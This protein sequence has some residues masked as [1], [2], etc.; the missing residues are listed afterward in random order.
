MDN[1]KRVQGVKRNYFNTFPPHFIPPEIHLFNLLFYL[2]FEE[3]FFANT[4]DIP[5]EKMVIKY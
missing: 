5:S 3:K 1:L 2:F 4:Q